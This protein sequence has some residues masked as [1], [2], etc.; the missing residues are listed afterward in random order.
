MRHLDDDDR[1]YLRDCVFC[2][3]EIIMSPGKS[4]GWVAL[5]LDY[6]GCHECVSTSIIT[7]PDPDK[8]QVALGSLAPF[9]KGGPP[10]LETLTGTVV[11]IEP[12]DHPRREGL[13]SVVLLYYDDRPW[14]RQEFR[15][16]IVVDTE[17]PLNAR[18]SGTVKR[19]LDVGTFL[20]GAK[21]IS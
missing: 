2:E 20:E 7:V 11:A 15:T 1:P 18:I 21:Q 14:L 17:F 12:R 10:M 16:Q 5:N 3:E 8:K 6:G 19:V 13:W 4:G 9:I